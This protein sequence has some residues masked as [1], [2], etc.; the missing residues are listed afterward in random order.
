MLEECE[1][2]KKEEQCNVA[3]GKESDQQLTKGGIGGRRKKEGTGTDT[4]GYI[5]RGAQRKGSLW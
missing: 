4:Q 1:V 5:A 3:Q 2:G